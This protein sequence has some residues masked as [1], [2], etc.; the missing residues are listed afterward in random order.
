MLT[1]AS[2]DNLAT[3]WRQGKQDRTDKR[4]VKRTLHL[5]QPMQ[6]CV[7]RRSR[8]REVVGGKPPTVNE[9]SGIG[10]DDQR[11]KALAHLQKSVSHPPSV[12]RIIHRYYNNYNI[13][14]GKAEGEKAKK[15][16]LLKPPAST[17][18]R[19]QSGSAELHSIAASLRIRSY[20]FVARLELD[21]EHDFKRLEA[22]FPPS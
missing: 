16:A 8:R 19:V 15:L 4:K 1:P 11:G 9:A 3:Q 22:R 7:L 21:N 12:K 6:L 20:N 10:I 13:R 2:R 14:K 17:I 5:F 18:F